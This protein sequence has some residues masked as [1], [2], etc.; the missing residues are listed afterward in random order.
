[1]AV[2]TDA[3]LLVRANQI[4]NETA[5]DANTTERVGTMLINIID[6]KGNT[7]S[8]S[9]MS[10]MADY[11]ASTNLFPDA[12]LGS[13]TGG[14]IRKGDTFD[15]SVGGV[16]GGVDV[17]AGATIRAKVANPG[18]TLANWRIMF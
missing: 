2:E 3:Q 5:D 8:G 9:P 18:Q 12:P 4:K 7:G 16:L 1:M 11:D 14:A 10:L 17:G 6:S 15:I 13:G